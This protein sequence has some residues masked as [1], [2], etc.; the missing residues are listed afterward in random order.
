M[1]EHFYH[2]I[3]YLIYLI[4]R[5]TSAQYTTAGGK[6]FIPAELLKIDIFIVFYRM[7]GTKSPEANKIFKKMR[8]KFFLYSSPI[9]LDRIK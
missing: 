4:T 2:T 8:H 1:R 7:R 9:A 5:K 6:N 3:I